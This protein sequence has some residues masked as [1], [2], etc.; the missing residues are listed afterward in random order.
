MYVQ[1]KDRFKNEYDKSFI[2]G[3]IVAKLS[4]EDAICGNVFLISIS[5]E[6]IAENKRTYFGG[7]NDIV[8]QTKISDEMKLLLKRDKFFVE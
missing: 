3:Y 4:S 1:Y 5:A 8:V 2:V 6:L 7:C